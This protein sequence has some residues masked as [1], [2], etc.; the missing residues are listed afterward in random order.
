MLSAKKLRKTI[1]IISSTIFLNACGDS[2]AGQAP[3]IN[4]PPSSLSSSRSDNST[5]SSDAST[6]ISR[7]VPINIP[8]GFMVNTILHREY[9]FSFQLQSQSLDSNLGHYRLE[10][11][12]RE[13]SDGEDL[14][15]SS[16]QI[17]DTK[18]DGNYYYVTV[19]YLPQIN[20]QNKHEARLIVTASDVNGHEV[21]QE[22]ALKGQEPF[23]VFVH[24]NIRAGQI[25]DHFAL[26]YRGIVS[27]DFPDNL[28][29]LYGTYNISIPTSNAWTD[30][31]GARFNF[32]FNVPLIQ[33]YN[34]A[35]T[36]FL[37][38]I[39]VK[40][41]AE[42]NSEAY[43]IIQYKPSESEIG[44]ELGSTNFND[45]MFNSTI[46]HH[47]LF[48]DGL[49]GHMAVNMSASLH[50]DSTAAQSI[51]INPHD[52]TWSP[53]INSLRI[54]DKIFNHE[55]SVTNSVLN[56]VS[57]DP[58]VIIKSINI[59]LNESD[60]LAFY[61]LLNDV[62][63]FNMNQFLSSNN[64]PL[65]V[66]RGVAS[67]REMF[68]N[69]SILKNRTFEQQQRAE[70][71]QHRAH[72]EQQQR[73]EEEQR[74]AH[75]EQQQR[76]EEEQRRA[77]AEQQQRAEEEQ[78]RAHAEQQQR[79]EEEQR[80]AHA[81]QQQRAEEEQRRA[82]AEQQQRAEEEQQARQ[83][84]QSFESANRSAEDIINFINQNFSNDLERYHREG[85]N[86]Y[87]FL[88]AFIKFYYNS[89][90]ATLE[91]FSQEDYKK[92]KR[93]VTHKVHPDILRRNPSL[94]GYSA[95]YFN[96]L[97]LGFQKLAV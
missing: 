32:P 18:R 77:H 65:A 29:K 88:R 33:T 15:A 70:E 6:R 47:A 25:S 53:A 75:A 40:L 59:L 94:R 93:I 52:G 37:N 91:K 2:S 1:Y 39:A 60:F 36:L 56:N 81:E 49:T 14:D 96:L 43:F 4:L 76:A 84:R 44:N 23:N 31:Y 3:S 58:G 92:I 11:V 64:M 10:S 20:N 41:E 22:I 9:E 66:Q 62:G 57:I 51:T 13:V 27:S 74:R 38:P 55:S 82:H 95:V 7:I 67:Y 8:S 16:F 46:K 35:Q 90:N 80:R 45:N 71:E 21:E 26:T 5:S 97:T 85:Y 24:R 86:F 50:I 83:E 17:M 42:D 69:T 79:A 63:N 12:I 30:S 73:A 19:R 89:H 48:S 68:V 34:P 72:A 28:S 78:R 61:S 54:K 87:P